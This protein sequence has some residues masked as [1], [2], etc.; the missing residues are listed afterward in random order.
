MINAG[1]INQIKNCVGFIF[2]QDDQNKITPQ[3]TRFFVTV[4][5]EHNP[6]KAVGHFVTAR[7][8]LE[9][10][11]CNF[12]DRFVLRLNKIDGGCDYTVVYHKTWGLFTHKDKDADIAVIPFRP[13]R[14]T[15]RLLINTI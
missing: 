2:M 4:P 3:G 6:Q 14:T 15:N 7:H 8:V 13:K 10:G 12:V 5:Q 11:S 1:I 9:D